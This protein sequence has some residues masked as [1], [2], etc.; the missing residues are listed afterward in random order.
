MLIKLVSTQL[1]LS[2]S[3]VQVTGLMM[4][5]MGMAHIVTKMVMY[6]KANGTAIRGMVVAYTPVAG[7]T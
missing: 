5:A 4:N 6:M 2:L 3:S 1:S 7:T